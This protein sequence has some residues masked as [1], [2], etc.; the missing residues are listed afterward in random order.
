MAGELESVLSPMTD[1]L[2]DIEEMGLLYQ[3]GFSIILIF[4]ALLSVRFGFSRL[5]W[6]IVKKT[7]N[8]WDNA[9]LG[10]VTNRL[11]IFVLSAGTEISIDWIDSGGDSAFRGGEPRR[12]GVGRLEESFVNLRRELYCII[13]ALDTIET[14]TTTDFH[15][16]WPQA[17]IFLLYTLFVSRKISVER[18]P[19]PYSVS[20]TL[21][22]SSSLQKPAPAPGAVLKSL[23]WGGD[24]AN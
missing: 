11:Y 14:V 24:S 1:G 5:A 18:L 7:E 12:L 22:I 19:A 4:I 21:K 10:P 23:F 16:P 15:R 8:E 17:T 13:P 3:L 6:R 9:A 2:K 20:Y